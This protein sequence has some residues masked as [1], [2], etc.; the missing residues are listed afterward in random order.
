MG[1]FGDILKRGKKLFDIKSRDGKF[2][3]CEECNARAPVYK[4]ID[5]EEQNWMLCET[6]IKDYIKED[7]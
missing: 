3:R 2:D 5:E 6:C 1:N 7:E 4:Y